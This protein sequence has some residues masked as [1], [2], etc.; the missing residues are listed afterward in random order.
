MYDAQQCICVLLS[1]RRALSKFHVPYSDLVSPFR[2]VRRVRCDLTMPCLHRLP[3]LAVIAFMLA[4]S[5][6]L[7]DGQSVY[8]QFLSG[9][10]SRAA[11]L[12]ML[13]SLASF[14]PGVNRVSDWK[15]ALISKPVLVFLH[16]ALAKLFVL[17]RAI[18]FG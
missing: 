3:V 4:I 17:H 18:C 1:L 5:S 2:L 7:S 6:E 11:L 12:I 14:A 9:G 8:V 13:I 15:R 10:A 16:P